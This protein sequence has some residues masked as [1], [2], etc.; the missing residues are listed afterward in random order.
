MKKTLLLFVILGL[1]LSVIVSVRVV[2]FA[3]QQLATQPLVTSGNWQDSNYDLLYTVAFSSEQQPNGPLVVYRASS[4]DLRSSVPVIAFA[5]SSQP[6]TP[7]FFPSPDGRYLALST[8]ITT[9][10]ASLNVLS[11]EGTHISNILVQN[12]APKDQ[13]LW[14][15]DSR[16]MYY[17]TVVQDRSLGNTYQA[18]HRSPAY[19]LNPAR[20][21]DEIHRIDMQ[22]HDVVL[23]H[24][25]QDGSSLHLIGV[26]ATGALVITLA[27]PRQPVEI[28]RV[29]V[30]ANVGQGQFHSAFV[31]LPKFLRL[32]PDI[33]PGN[34]LHVSSDGTAIVCERV[35]SWS[36]LRYTLIHINLNNGSISSA[37]TN[38]RSVIQ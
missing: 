1:L 19:I 36:P 8:P 25:V 4:T 14:T 27:R 28:V 31:R 21:Y 13:V 22:G 26:D 16:F 11:S 3:H 30:H 9:H 6:M 7:L 33:L 32:P 5:R 10:Q 17:H 18:K 15:A 35:L 37:H 20:G 38:S 24:H 2:S 29:G 23:L 12:L 34:V